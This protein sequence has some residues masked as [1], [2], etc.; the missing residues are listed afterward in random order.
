VECH[1]LAR[2]VTSAGLPL[3]IFNFSM[4]A[5]VE[6]NGG[7]QLSHYL[8]RMRLRKLIKGKFFPFLSI[9]MRRG[10]HKLI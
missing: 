8:S 2:A 4:I 7:V 10:T 9:F 3:Q 6:L 5:T 1:L